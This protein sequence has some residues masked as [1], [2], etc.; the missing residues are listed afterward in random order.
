VVFTLLKI[1]LIVMVDRT[2]TIR[3]ATTVMDT[4][5]NS[6]VLMVMFFSI[7]LVNSLNHF[8][9]CTTYITYR[10]AKSDFLLFILKLFIPASMAKTA[11]DE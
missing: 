2:V 7:D 5:V 1:P 10:S 4:I 3:S 8:L 9:Y 11:I 6:L